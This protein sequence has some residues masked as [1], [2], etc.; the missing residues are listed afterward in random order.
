MGKHATERCFLKRYTRESNELVYEYQTTPDERLCAT[1]VVEDF[2]DPRFTGQ[3]RADKHDTETTAAQAFKQDRQVNE[4]RRW[5]APPMWLIRKGTSLT[6]TQ[7]D[8]LD[9]KGFKSGTVHKD[10]QRCIFNG[11]RALGCRHSLWDGNT[12]PSG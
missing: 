7:K 11:F 5:L 4:V 1:L 2:F 12:D 8:E 10:M 3:Y 9:E 6:R